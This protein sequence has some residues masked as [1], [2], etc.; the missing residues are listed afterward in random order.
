MPNQRPPVTALA[1]T[2]RVQIFERLADG[3]ISV[4][5]LASKFPIS[6]PAVSQHLSVLKSAGLIHEQ[7]VGTSRLYA[8][9]ADSVR[10]LRDYFDHFWNRA[11][12]FKPAAK[13]SDEHEA[14]GA[15]PLCEAEFE[16]IE[17]GEAFL[18]PVSSLDQGAVLDL[19]LEFLPEGKRV[20]RTAL[21]DA[22]ARRLG[23]SE[24]SKSLR[25][26]INRSIRYG[27]DRG[28]LQVDGKWVEVW[29]RSR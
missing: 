6:R 25:S 26:C 27:V 19:V 5:E 22:V 12:A 1:D 18:E 21:L 10:A 13:Q 16:R 3:P 11:S 4:G 15:A 9:D 24:M 23:S 28:V 29:R 7:R 2:T 8:L 17:A 20:P 14:K